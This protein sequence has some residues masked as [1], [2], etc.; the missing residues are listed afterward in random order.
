LHKP[1]AGR[2]KRQAGNNDAQAT[3]TRNDMADQNKPID[4]A[5]IK[6]TVQ[7]AAG[8]LDDAALADVSGGGLI[9]LNITCLWSCAGKSKEAQQ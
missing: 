5:K 2:A 4:V 9:D 6:E 1:D 8:S 7:E 3:E